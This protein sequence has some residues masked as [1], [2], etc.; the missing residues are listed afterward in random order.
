MRFQSTKFVCPCICKQA[1]EM[2]QEYGLQPK[3]ATVVV[4]CDSSAGGCM[5]DLCPCITRSRAGSD[6]H[7]LIFR[8]RRLGLDD[9][10]RL[11]GVQPADVV[12]P[13]NVSYRQMC[14]M[15]GN[16]FS[17][18]VISAISR[19]LLSSVGLM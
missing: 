4:D 7:W 11:Q 9:M 3:R 16:A 12:I 13:E 17:A 15:V 14:L 10:L 19:E 2:C 18:N 6:G 8:G 1:L 5:W